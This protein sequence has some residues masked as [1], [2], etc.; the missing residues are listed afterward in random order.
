MENIEGAGIGESK[1][2]KSGQK[3]EGVGKG[4]EWGGEDL[5]AFPKM[6]V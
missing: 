5:P 6:R 4:K 1:G 2:V 3:W